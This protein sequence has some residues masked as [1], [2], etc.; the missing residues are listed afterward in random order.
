MTFRFAT[1]FTA[2][3]ILLFLAACAVSPKPVYG[4]AL[5]TFAVYY[6]DTA[7]ASDFAPYDV[8]VFDDATHPPLA[9]LRDRPRQILAYVS[10]GELRQDKADILAT[11]E[12]EGALWGQHPYWQSYYVDITHPA[13]EHY[14]LYE[15]LPAIMAKGFDGVML[16]TVDSALAKGITCKVN[17][18]DYLVKIIT[19]IRAKYP[20]IKIMINRGLPLISAIHDSIDY[21]LAESIYIN[22]NLA[23]GEGKIYPQ[24]QLEQNVSFLQQAALKYSGLVVYSLDYWN[25]EDADGILHIYKKQRGWGFV[26]YVATPDLKRLIIEPKPELGESNIK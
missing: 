3:C 17:T 7:P 11:L 24:A 12:A 23:S 19:A 20:D 25:P 9:P 21:I 10:L 1:L 13:W 8:I 22:F 2:L 14:L 4:P 16:D 5:P 26:P 18:Y 6:G 15:Q